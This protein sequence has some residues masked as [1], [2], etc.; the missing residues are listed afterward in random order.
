MQCDGCGGYHFTMLG[1]LGNTTHL[2]CRACGLDSHIDS[3]EL[4]ELEEEV[5]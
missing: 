2:R 5:S 1:T 4:E 3:E